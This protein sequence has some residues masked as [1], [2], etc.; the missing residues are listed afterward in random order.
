M[1]SNFGDI[2]T[3]FRFGQLAKAYSPIEVTEVG[4]TTVVRCGMDSNAEAWI[5][6]MEVG[7]T[8]EY[9]PLN[10]SMLTVMTVTVVGMKMFVRD[11]QRENAAWPIL[12]IVVGMYIYSMSVQPPWK[13]KSATKDE[14]VA[15]IMFA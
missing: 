5:E 12:V 15:M 2:T 11:A 7:I 6:T 9:N 10:C 3:Q 1:Y 13:A 4:M 8:I 14:F